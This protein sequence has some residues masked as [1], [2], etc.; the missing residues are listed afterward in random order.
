MSLGNFRGKDLFQKSLF[1]FNHWLLGKKYHPAGKNFLPRFKT[2]F[3]VVLETFRT[4]DQ[5]NISRSFSDP[6]KRK[7]A[8]GKFCWPNCQKYNL[9]F[10]K[11]F[12]RRRNFFREKCSFSCIFGLWA[13]FV[14]PFIKTFSAGLSKWSLLDAKDPLWGSLYSKCF[15]HFRSLSKK[16]GGFCIKSSASLSNAF[17]VSRR[18]FGG[19]VVFFTS[20]VFSWTFCDIERK[21]IGWVRKLFDK[22][23]KTAFS[24]SIGSFWGKLPNPKLFVCFFP[25]FQT[26]TGKNYWLFQVK[27][28]HSCQI[29]ILRVQGD[30]L[31]QFLSKKNLFLQKSSFSPD[32][33]RKL[34][35]KFRSSG[36]VFLAVFF[37]TS[38]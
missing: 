8:C 16:T 12:L 19:K 6:E 1:I 24:V 28:P 11:N 4:T 5:R 30:L 7:S 10:Q 14:Q 3:F 29:W 23:V 13:N 26:L 15:L 18:T 33:F 9:G 25:H 2:A 32:I 22:V 35:K 17:E 27:I 34:T 20:N 37:R 21:K 38:F 31:W 36:K